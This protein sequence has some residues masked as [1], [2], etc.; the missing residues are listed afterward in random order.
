MFACGTNDPIWV[1]TYGPQGTRVVQNITNTTRFNLSCWNADATQGRTDSVLVQVIQPTTPT[2]PPA[3]PTPSQPA[4]NPTVTPTRISTPSPTTTQPVRTDLK[5]NGSDGPV[6]LQPGQQITVTWQASG[7]AITCATNDPS[8]A[9]TYPISGSRSFVPSS[10]TRKIALSCWNSTGTSSSTDS[11][12]VSF[13]IP[14][15]TPTVLTPTVTTAPP[16]SFELKANNSTSDISIPAGQNVTLS[17]SAQ[18][19]STCATNDPL[20]QGSYSNTGSIQISNLRNTTTFALSCWTGAGENS[21]T[22]RIRVTVTG[23]VPQP[24][25]TPAAAWMDFRANDITGSITIRSGQSVVLSWN[26]NQL[27]TCATN[28]SLWQGTY[29]TTGTRVLSN[30]TSTTRVGLSCW[31]ADASISKTEYITINVN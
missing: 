11:V 1:G 7:P 24:T 15:P 16:T 8:W 21:Q 19:A 2:Q 20:W 3:T 22:K 4:N 10:L 30:L 25:P 14:T 12:D 27:T 31:N 29:P 28:D 13:L 23:T 5:V 18:Y 6:T 9:S 17:W 26:S